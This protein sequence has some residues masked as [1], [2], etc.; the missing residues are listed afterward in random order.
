MGFDS[1][2]DLMDSILGLKN[3]IIN[4]F[5]AIIAGSSSFITSYIWDDASAVYFLLFLVGIDA[6][7]GVWKAYKYKTFRRIY[8]MINDGF[9]QILNEV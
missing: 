9:L 7:T 5:M 1:F 3:P 4:F 2:K 6:F 8:P